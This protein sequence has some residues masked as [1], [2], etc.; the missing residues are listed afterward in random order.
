[1]KKRL[2]IAIL[3]AAAAATTHAEKVEPINFGNFDQWVTREI[4]ESKLLGGANKT[5]YEI[6]P[7]QTITTGK[8][9]TNLGG[10]PWATSN[11]LASPMGVTKTSNAVF[12]DV[13]GSGKCAKL[14]TLY[15]HCKVIGVVNMEVLVAGS[16]F[17]GKMLEPI[18]STSNPYSKM[19]MGVP[20]TRRPKALQFDYK[21]FMP[22]TGE[23]IYSSGFGKKKTY[24]GNDCAEVFII[25][26]RRW[27]DADGNIHAKRV[28]TGRERYAKTTD[29]VAAHRIPVEYGDI[30]GRAGFKA[31]KGLIPEEK[32]YY[33]KNSKG[34]MVPVVEE[35]WDAADATP[36]HLLVM[37]S[38][39]SG[40]AYIGTI[41]L[42]LWVYN[43]A[44]L[45]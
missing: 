21:L 37:F 43:V 40:S 7:T 4:K 42:T 44:L 32:S 6:G 30:S 20:F 17:L 34:K 10:S 22:S 19:E 13:H 45:Y 14:T 39:G 1:M 28:G 33:A 5:I 15:E 36:T 8:P 3:C 26:Q 31:W 16:V 41:D 24:K 29:W 9:Y 2:L 23:R 25:L 11:V 18:K 35:G 27:E 12:P 38:A